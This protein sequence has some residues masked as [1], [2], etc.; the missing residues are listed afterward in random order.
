MAHPQI[1]SLINLTQIL[2]EIPPK[3]TFKMTTFSSHLIEKKTNR[4]NKIATLCLNIKKWSFIIC[5]EHWLNFVQPLNFYAVNPSQVKN[6]VLSSFL[7]IWI[8]HSLFQTSTILINKAFKR[9]KQVKPTDIV[10]QH[11]GDLMK[12][13]SRKDKGVMRMSKHW[14]VS[15]AYLF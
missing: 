12:T 14:E 1:R 5:C 10:S 6:N 4:I 8:F 11:F 2:S 7:E 15:L 3:C 13:L 9:H